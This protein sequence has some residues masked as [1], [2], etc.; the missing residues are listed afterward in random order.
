M[1]DRLASMISSTDRQRGLLKPGDIIVRRSRRRL[2][3]KTDGRRR[4]DAFHAPAVAA[5]VASWP[6]AAADFL[7]AHTTT[8]VAR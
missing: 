7:L 1:A 5:A 4:K 8:T 2:R 6:A 3:G